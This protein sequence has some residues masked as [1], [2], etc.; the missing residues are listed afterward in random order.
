MRLKYLDL[1]KWIALIAMVIDHLRFL[2]P[3]ASQFDV[4]CYSI[5]R[6]AYPLFLFLMAHYFYRSRAQQNSLSS[7][8]RYIKNLVIYAFLSEIPYRLYFHD[9]NSLNIFPSLILCF[10]LLYAYVRQPKYNQ[11]YFF[12]PILI[13][14]V[15]HQTAFS[16][17][18]DVLGVYAILCFYLA[19][20]NRKLIFL[21]ILASISL[22]LYL[23]FNL[24][25]GFSSILNYNL[26]RMSLPFTLLLI[27]I[28]FLSYFGLDRKINFKIFQVNKWAYLF[29]PAHLLIL[30]FI[31]KIF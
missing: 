19:F 23:V 10:V 21:P 1:I 3:S 27:I 7:D 22:N 31:Q 29:Y 26:W 30:L 6:V 28:I 18:Y 24:S 20:V 5:G 4:W 11:I 13:I 15:L 2:N 17:Q 25:E 9:S 12:I 14:L 16:I 8:Q